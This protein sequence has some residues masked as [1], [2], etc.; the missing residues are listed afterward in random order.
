MHMN[1]LTFSNQIL[2]SLC[3]SVRA[4]AWWSDHRSSICPKWSA[5]P[6]L[7]GKKEN[8]KKEKI[9]L[10]LDLRHNQL[11]QNRH[12]FNLWLKL[13]KGNKGR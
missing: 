9:G 13:A 12:Y 10:E 11:N 1:S 5:L 6:Q 7:G 8:R 4:I 2:P 3:H